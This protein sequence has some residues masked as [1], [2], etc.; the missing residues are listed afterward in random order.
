MKRM[1]QLLYVC[2]RVCMCVFVCKH[3]WSTCASCPDPPVQEH[4]L[5]RKNMSN[6]CTR[7]HAYTHIS[8]PV[9]T[10]GLRRKIYLVF[11]C[12]QELQ[13]DWVVA[14]CS[15]KRCQCVH[16]CIICVEISSSHVNMCVCVCV[17]I[18]TYTCMHAYM[19]NLYMHIS[20][21]CVCVCLSVFVCV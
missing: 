18:Y 20:Y 11:Q 16:D 14:C 12:H 19:N 1:S 9:Q 3:L 15:F 4:S 21:L 17:C 7:M 6:T 2:I 5:Y 13:L 8:V 10:H